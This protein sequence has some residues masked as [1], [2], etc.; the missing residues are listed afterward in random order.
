VSSV[1][2][3]TELKPAWW[4][5]VIATAVVLGLG[6][7]LL[8]FD[9]GERIDH[10]LG[11]TVAWLVCPLAFPL[12]VSPLVAL[13]SAWDARRRLAMGML[14]VTCFYIAHL[15]PLGVAVVPY[16]LPH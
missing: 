1:S 15:L 14:F 13:L 11:N 8:W 16:F 10:H 4:K 7:G 9:L 2:E 3:P 12:L 6:S 5:A